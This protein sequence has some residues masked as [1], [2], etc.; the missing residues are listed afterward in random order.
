MK[1]VLLISE[2]TI[3][4]YSLVNDNVDGK[5][6]LPAI[7]TTQELDLETV[8]GP[9][10]VNKLC[11]LVASGDIELDENVH[12]KDLLDSFVT[13][14]LVWQV[15]SSIQIGVNYKFTNSGI[16]GNDDERKNRLDYRNAQLLQEQYNNYAASYANKLKNYLCHNSNLF[17]EYHQSVNGETEQDVFVGGIYLSD[18][19]NCKNSYLYK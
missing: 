7:Q 5:Y 2:A 1:K 10:L 18:V 13:P 16:V 8:I 19:P 17:P 9:A 14:Y 11:S 12:Y 3:K 4:K 15:M 6:I